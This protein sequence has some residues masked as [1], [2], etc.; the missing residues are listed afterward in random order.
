MSDVNMSE[1]LGSLFRLE[2]PVVHGACHP[3]EVR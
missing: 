2:K 3:T 1:V